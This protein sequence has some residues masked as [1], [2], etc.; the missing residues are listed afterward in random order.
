MMMMMMMM[1]MMISRMMAARVT[2]LNDG[3]D[4]ASPLLLIELKR[5]S[6]TPYDRK[7]CLRSGDGFV[8]LWDADYWGEGGQDGEYAEPGHFD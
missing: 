5:G 3:D 2:T 8:R 1:M 7:C 4:R 6:T